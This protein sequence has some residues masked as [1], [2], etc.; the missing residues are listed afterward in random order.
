MDVNGLL[1][2]IAAD[3]LGVQ[4]GIIES[5]LSTNYCD[6]INF[7]NFMKDVPPAL[8]SLILML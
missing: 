7:K 3:E 1:R 2:F 8:I 6:F 4:F 5:A